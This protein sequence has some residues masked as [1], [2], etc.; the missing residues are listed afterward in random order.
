MHCTPRT[1]MKLCRERGKLFVTCCFRFAQ[2]VEGATVEES[3]EEE[4]PQEG[5]QAE[6][7]LRSLQDLEKLFSLHL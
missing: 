3:Q 7:S 5:A 4:Q 1:E 6:A 2:A